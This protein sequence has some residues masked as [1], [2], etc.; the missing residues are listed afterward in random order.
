MVKLIY[1]S[2][3]NLISNGIRYSHANHNKSDTEQ[4][5]K[6]TI[7][8]KD[9]DLIKRIGFKYKHESVLEHSLLIF[10]IECSRALLQELARHRHQSLTVKSS[11]YTLKEL[12]EIPKESIDNLEVFDK[13]L[14][15]TNNEAINNYNRQQLRAL[16]EAY[17][18]HYVKSNDVAKYAIPEAFKTSLQLSLNLRSL[19]NLLVLRIS[20]EALWEFQLLSRDIIDSLPDDYKELIFENEFIK[21]DEPNKD[22]YL[23]LSC[24]LELEE[25]KD[26]KW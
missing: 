17:S 7:G 10:D 13:F 26:I 19:I 23:F 1:S 9:Y 8:S 21:L 20:K 4:I 18:K 11:R 24:G 6:D 16:Y 12:L 22:K 15:L 5:G 25:L 3:L 2:P 14:F